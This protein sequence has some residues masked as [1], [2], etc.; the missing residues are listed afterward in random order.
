MNLIS[1][2]TYYRL[3]NDT[4]E[5]TITDE[6][7][8]IKDSYLV[9]SDDKKLEIID[10][11]LKTFIWFKEHRTSKDMLNEWRVHNQLYKLNIKKEHTK[12]V[13][14]EYKQ[15]IFMKFLYWL[16]SRFIKRDV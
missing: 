13:D 6:N 9:M 1:G 11:L 3:E 14:F 16:I 15:N 10:D 2:I 7:I 12:S 8:N 4:I 5:C